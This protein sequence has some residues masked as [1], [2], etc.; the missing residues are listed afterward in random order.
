MRFPGKRAFWWYLVLLS[1]AVACFFSLWA[2][3]RDPGLVSLVS[4]S[5]MVLS[6][7][8]A[9]VIQF[10]NDL[11]LEEDSL[12]LRFGPLTRRI[13]YR[14]IEKVNRTRNP[15]SSTATSLDRLALELKEGGL[16]LVSAKDND[17]FIRQ[18]QIRIDQALR[19]EEE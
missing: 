3:V 18:L 9:L 11:T 7:F 2:A 15:L 8:S 14:E 19:G 5:L 10:R 17:L 1:L 16:V 4:A 6:L 12:L 13:P